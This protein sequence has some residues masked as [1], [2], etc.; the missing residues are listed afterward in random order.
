ME[1]YILDKKLKK[2]DKKWLFNIYLLFQ[3]PEQE[4]VAYFA[5]KT[6]LSF[7]KSLK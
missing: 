7:H 2:R 3:L 4:H 5:K 1:E 6:L